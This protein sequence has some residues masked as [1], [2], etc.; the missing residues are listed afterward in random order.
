MVI[1]V[2]TTKE[3]I[4]EAFAWLDEHEMISPI[5]VD[6]IKKQKKSEYDKKRYQEKVKSTIST[7]EKVENEEGKE[8]GFSP[9]SP[10]SLPSSPSDSPNNYPITPY[11]PPLPEEREPISGGKA[12]KNRYGNF[13]H[14]LL[15]PEEDNKLCQ[16]FGLHDTEVRIQRLDDY[17]ENNRKKH[18]DNHYLT[19]LNWARRDEEKNPQPKKT[20]TAFEVAEMMERG[21]L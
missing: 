3:E 6:E 20:Y 19:I 1:I 5:S 21:E 10:S 17:L 9:L 11:N 16:K 13:G 18:Y 15:T 14:V 12:K 4:K 7:V 8:A 2:A